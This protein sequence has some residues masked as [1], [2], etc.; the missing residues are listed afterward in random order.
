M[1]VKMMPQASRNLLL[2]V[3]LFLLAFFVYLRSDV[4]ALADPLWAIHISASLLQSGDVNLDEYEALVVDVNYFGAIPK[5]ADGHIQPFFPVGNSVLIAP[6]VWLIGLVD[7]PEGATSFYSYIQKTSP[8]D[9]HLRFIQRFTASL[10][11]ALTVLV[12]YAIGKRQVNSGLAALGAL[13]F[14]FGTSAFSIAS[15]TLW[16]HGPSML[17]L[18]LALYFIIRAEKNPRNLVYAGA[19]LAFSY[20]IRPTNSIAILVFSI[21]VIIRH[22]EQAWRYF[23][24]ALLIAI[25][26]LWLNLVT[27]NMILPPYYAASRIGATTNF[28]EA[29]VGN[30]VSPGRGLL[31]FTPI[32]LFAAYGAFI[33]IRGSKK[34]G[35]D[36]ALIVIIV[37]HWT[38]ISSFWHWWG[39]HSFGP[40]LFSDM[41][42]FLIYFIF[43]VLA[44]LG[45]LRQANLKRMIMLAL[46]LVLAVIS[47]LIHSRGANEEAVWSWNTVPVEVDRHASSRLWDWSDLQFLRR[48]EDWPLHPSPRVLLISPESQNELLLISIL[49]RTTKPYNW[50]LATPSS[51]KVIKNSEMRHRYS[52]WGTRVIEG[53]DPLEANQTQVIPISLEEP[54]TSAGDYS[55]GAIVVTATSVDDSTQGSVVMPVSLEKEYYFRDRSYS[56]AHDLMLP[57][58]VTVDEREP[59]ADLYALHGSG[60]YRSESLEEYTWRW[61]QSPAELYIYAARPRSISLE[62]KATSLYDPSVSN[63]LGPEGQLQIASENYNW[64][65]SVIRDQEFR[66][67]L[68][69]QRGW[70]KFVFSLE[71]GNFRPNELQ[72]TSGDR[73]QLSFALAPI[74]L[75][76]E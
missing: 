64:E 67:P 26:F 5:N 19:A 23:G 18:A 68:P 39:G 33:R 25:P 66:A 61:A 48:S 52:E 60:W 41:M 45:N 55:L 69:L 7:K 42:P 32:L 8:Y 29:L 40:R 37:L 57:R 44:V 15:R 6:L 51:L 1:T 4:S 17:M 34:N 50:E 21:F 24:G 54:Q 46:F 71:E 12:I 75:V 65:Q 16:Q 38:A 63:G 59:G 30:L 72:P 13:L 36:L 58:D 9:L 76:S 27:Y 73:R 70:N 35:L 10:V 11:T 74:N 43:P 47:V 14:A 62:L 49:N 20:V 22:R 2:P 3:F 53:R 31:I 56:L 28:A